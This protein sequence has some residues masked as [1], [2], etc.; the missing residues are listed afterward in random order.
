MFVFCLPERTTPRGCICL[1]LYVIVHPLWQGWCHCIKDVELIHLWREH[2]YAHVIIKVLMKAIQFCFPT[3]FKNINTKNKQW[4]YANDT[5]KG[6]TINNVKGWFVFWWKDNKSR[7]S[8]GG[9]NSEFAV[10]STSAVMSEKW[11]F[12]ASLSVTAIQSEATR[13]ITINAKYLY[14]TNYANFNLPSDNFIV[15]TITK[16]KNWQKISTCLFWEVVR[17]SRKLDYR[18][19]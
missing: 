9:A 16:K 1:Q 4:M 15:D 7:R 2:S 13:L 18:K 3:S 10:I 8:V 6:H 11:K 17:C 19:K 14:T 5:N 12:R